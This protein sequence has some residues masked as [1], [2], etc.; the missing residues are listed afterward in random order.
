MSQSPG[1]SRVVTHGGSAAAPNTPYGKLFGTSKTIKSV[2]LNPRSP[3]ENGRTVQGGIS[4]K[5]TN[6][7]SISGATGA[8]GGV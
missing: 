1:I 6:A 7:T 3:L 8:S 2:T 5:A 4:L